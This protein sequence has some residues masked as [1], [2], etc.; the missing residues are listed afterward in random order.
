MTT[1]Y[2]GAKLSISAT[3]PSDLTL[4]AFQAIAFVTGDCAVKEVPAI[5]RS[6]DKVTDE[7]VCNNSSYDIKGG[8]KWDPLAFKINRKPSDEA[9]AIYEALEDDS[10]GVGA[11]KLEL[12]GGAGTIYFIAQVSK[13]ALADGGTKNTIHTSG[14]E[15]CLQAD[16][17]ADYAAA[18]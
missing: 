4:A 1:T 7:T 14:V 9:Q 10:N 8:A 3:V 17:I 16:P 15:L 12:P 13:F 5:M 18:A 11:F 2:S 6:W